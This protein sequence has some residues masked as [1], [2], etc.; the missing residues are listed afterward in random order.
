MDAWRRGIRANSTHDV[1]CPA[2]L[3]EIDPGGK[4]DMCRSCECAAGRRRS[5]AGERWCRSDAARYDRA[6]VMLVARTPAD[7]QWSRLV[8]AARRSLWFVPRRRW[9]PA[10]QVSAATLIVV[11]L[12]PSQSNKAAPGR[13]FV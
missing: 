7:P 5:A 13:M 2:A 11:V 8:R 6:S 9:S 3:I 4:L 1:P 10:V 12:P